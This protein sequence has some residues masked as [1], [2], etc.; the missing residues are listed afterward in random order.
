MDA[1]HFVQLL[2]S[3]DMLQPGAFLRL[4]QILV[5]AACGDSKDRLADDGETTR[6]L[7]LELCRGAVEL[8][9]EKRLTEQEGSPLKGLAGT[10]VTAKGAGAAE[11]REPPGEAE[12]NAAAE[13]SDEDTDYDDMP[14]LGSDRSTSSEDE[15]EKPRRDK[16]RGGGECC[17]RGVGSRHGL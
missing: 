12:V 5:S 17:R 16:G 11:E 13:E 10:H 9:L 8:I 4:A 1:V 7:T 6:Q 3:T 15:A 14:E 2:G